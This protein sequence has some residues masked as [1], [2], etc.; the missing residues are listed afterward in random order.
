MSSNGQNLRVIDSKKELKTLKPSLGPAIKPLH[1]IENTKDVDELR[2]PI[3]TKPGF[4]ARSDIIAN[5]PT[6]ACPKLDPSENTFDREFL[7]SALGNGVRTL[8]T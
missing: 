7:K 6:V 5:L 8:L 3:A 4:S 2:H 1:A